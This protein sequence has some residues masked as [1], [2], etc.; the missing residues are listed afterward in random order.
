V[1]NSSIRPATPDDAPAIAALSRLVYPYLV[2]GAAS[3]Q[4]MIAEP[5]PGE[6]WACFVATE[7]GEVVGRVCAYRNTRSADPAFGRVSM[8]HVHPGHRRRGLGTALFAAAAAH[9]RSAGVRRAAATTTVEALPFARRFGFEPTRELRYSALDLRSLAVAAPAPGVVSI[10]E[11]DPVALYRADVAAATDEPGDT[12]LVASS[13]ESWRY[14]VWDSVDLDH[15]ASTAALQGAEVV[16]FSL[17]TRDGDRV[18]SD[19]TATT[20]SHR[21]RGL[22]RLVKTAALH[23]AAA[24]GA[25]TAYTSNDESN[26]PMLAVNTRLGYRRIATQLSCLADL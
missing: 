7:S 9:L 23:R 20:P 11:L 18:W 17:L 3:Y 5:P 19:M 6:D 26:A 22:A 14:D 12:P 13:Y 8:L 2:R 15:D 24:A 1:R 10:G 4:R 25:L 21:G 16:S